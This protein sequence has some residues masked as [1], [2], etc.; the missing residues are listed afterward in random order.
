MHPGPV[1]LLERKKP[2]VSQR[3]PGFDS[4]LFQVLVK[5]RKLCLQILQ[6]REKPWRLRAVMVLTLAHDLQERI[7]RNNYAAG[8]EL[9]RRYK[10]E[11]AWSWFERKLRELEER[12]A[13]TGPPARH[14]PASAGSPGKP[15]AAAGRLEAVSAGSPAGA[16]PGES[17][18][19]SRKLCAL[20]FR[21]RRRNS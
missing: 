13:F 3:W 5:A 19:E 21:M 8:E 11:K 2:G 6:N 1:R 12:E 14:A 10:T 18:P 16:G 15:A 9:F 7:R 17:G 4:G 20:C